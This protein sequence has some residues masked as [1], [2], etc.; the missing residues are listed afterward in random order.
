MKPWEEYQPKPWEEYQ[1]SK[2][3]PPV[4]TYKQTAKSDS[5]LDN[6]LAGIGG[7]MM[8]MYHGAKQFLGADNQAE[9]NEHRKAMGG[10]RS[11]AGGFAGDIVGQASLA[12]PAMAI[13]GANTYVGASLLGAGLG[14]VQP[15]L[16][17]ESRAF[18]AGMGLVGGA[19]GKYA[20]DKVAKM[21]TGN[22]SAK[23]NPAEKSARDVGKKLGFKQTPGY[24][25]GSK[26]LKKLEAS[27][28]SNPF[29]SRPIDKI[30]DHNQATVNRI[31]AKSL[32]EKSDT[33]DSVTLRTIKNKI[34][35]TYKKV[36]T[37]TKR[38]LDADDITNR[39]ADIETLY[40]DL[41]PE[42]GLL[43]HSGSTRKLFNIAAKG[44]AT[45]RELQQLSSKLN[46]AAS[47]QMTSPAGD[48]D[49]GLALYDVKDVVDD[50]LQEGLSKE[51]AKEF[52]TARRQYR[53]LIQLTK[54]N[55]VINPSSGDVHP[56]ALANYLQQTDKNGFL[57][58][59]NQSDLYNAARFAQAFKPIVGDSGTST[60][61]LL[62]TD[63]PTLLMSPFTNMAAGA[64]TSRPIA[65]G[66]NSLLQLE[67]AS[68]PYLGQM[69]LLG[70]SMV[71]SQSQ[72]R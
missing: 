53:T 11:T 69:G 62:N 23:L 64:Y 7:G 15:T 49:M 44:E 10:L 14:T 3:K 32:G 1:Q 50:Y 30:K 58:G 38:S 31:A 68:L 59:K 25:S 72:A 21:L 45:G 6:T 33:L 43:N 18:N 41:L 16:E 40:D 70:G 29:F 51:L 61:A 39:I 34:G 46:K 42:G 22:V 60:R 48:R 20:G 19:A 37:D 12:A 57:F 13:P 4:D 52:A 56:I 17:G 5:V 26:G 65:A 35:D 55:N 71:G 2:T 47:K 63:I 36:A 27:M 24:S 67:R 54:R 9:I 28:E 66:A 8:S